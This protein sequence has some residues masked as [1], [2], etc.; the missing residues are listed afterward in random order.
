[1]SARPVQVNDVNPDEV[2]GLSTLSL[3]VTEESEKDPSP[4]KKNHPATL[5]GSAFWALFVVRSGRR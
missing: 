5:E 2:A 1:M 4:K 3:L